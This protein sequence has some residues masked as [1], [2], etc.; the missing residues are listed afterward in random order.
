MYL[1]NQFFSKHNINFKLAISNLLAV[2]LSTFLPLKVCSYHQLNSFFNLTIYLQGAIGI[3]IMIQ[4]IS[5]FGTLQYGSI[6][7]CC[8]TLRSLGGP[9]W[10]GVVDVILKIFFSNSTNV[11]ASDTLDSNTI[12]LQYS[13]DLW[14]G[15]KISTNY[16]FLFY[17]Y[18][19][20][21]FW[22]FLSLESNCS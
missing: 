20:V 13:M 11:N 10:D 2:L 12:A 22:K 5:V 6:G 4:G 18:P 14:R 9:K 21:T 19:K 17:R 8:D 15:I 1:F 16:I 7:L 3:E